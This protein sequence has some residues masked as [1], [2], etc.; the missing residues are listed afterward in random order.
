MIFGSFAQKTA[1]RGQAEEP[2][3]TASTHITQIGIALDR[4]KGVIASDAS[5]LVKGL[6]MKTLSKNLDMLM[7]KIS[8]TKSE[9]EKNKLYDSVILLI[10]NSPEIKKNNEIMA[11]LNELVI[12]NFASSYAS[13]LGI[14]KEEISEASKKEMLEYFTEYVRN[15]ASREENAKKAVADFAKEMMINDKVLRNSDEKYDYRNKPPAA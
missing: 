15:L 6:D 3:E 4:A 10:F 2:L 1:V 5:E 11:K 9:N 8:E 12:D 13:T 7:K 14:E